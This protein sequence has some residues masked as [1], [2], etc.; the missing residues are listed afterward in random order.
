MMNVEKKTIRSDIPGHTGYLSGG[1]AYGHDDMRR[2]VVGRGINLQG[3]VAD[4]DHLVVEGLVEAEGF[5]ARRL[6]ITQH[7]AFVGA[8]QI[9]DAFIAGR[10]EGKLVVTGRLVVRAAGQIF[11]DISYGALEVEAGAT[12]E[13]QVSPYKAKAA[14]VEEKPAATVVAIAAS[15]NVENLFD[16]VDDEDDSRLPKE[17]NN[18][19]RRAVRF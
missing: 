10:F 13:G 19:F 16:A 7:G 2:M 12:I 17:R 8:A 4:C 11:G 15:S 1:M 18:V 9:E 14:V 3:A 6:D 5:T